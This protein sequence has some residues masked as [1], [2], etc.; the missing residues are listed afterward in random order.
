MGPKL[1]TLS[2]ST[3]IKVNNYLFHEVRSYH[4]QLLDQHQASLLI[5]QELVLPPVQVLL[6][7]IHSP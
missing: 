1:L 3:K 4:C 7:V 6:G 5:L 2:I